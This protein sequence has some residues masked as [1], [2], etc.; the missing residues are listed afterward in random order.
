MSEILGAL[1][2][3]LVQLLGIAAI[4]FV[5]YQVF[6]SNKVSTAITDL[7]QL[8]TQAQSFYSGQST[9]TTLTNAVAISAKLAP[10]DMISGAALVNPWNA[11]TVTVNVNAGSS[12]QFDVTET[13][14]PT[15]GCSKMAVGL[16]SAIALKINGTAQT[17]PMDAGTAAT[18]CNVASNT[19]I[20]TF[21]H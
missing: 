2:K 15:D 17:I 12:A 18:A 3:Y 19:L 6:G 20:F 10:T 8:S 1:F 4:A 11:G 16:P 14:V 9:F 7:T 21:S 13:A 5:L